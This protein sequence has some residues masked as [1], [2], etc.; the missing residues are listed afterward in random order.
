MHGW[1]KLPCGAAIVTFRSRDLQRCAAATIIVVR[2][3]VS[4]TLS[5][6]LPKSLNL[7]VETLEFTL[8][9]QR[10]GVSL[11]GSLAPPEQTLACWA[12]IDQLTARASGLAVEAAALAVQHQHLMVVVYLLRIPVGRQLC[13]EHAMRRANRQLG[14]DQSGAGCDPMMVAV[15]R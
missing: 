12:Q 15:H 1:P 10:R 5:G 3:T 2:S 14:R 11:G 8:Y 4:W 13:C 9:W 7:R 6:C